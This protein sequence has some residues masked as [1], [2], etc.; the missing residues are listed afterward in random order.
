MEIL[1]KLQSLVGKKSSKNDDALAEK[2]EI[3]KAAKIKSRSHIFVL[4]ALEGVKKLE[5]D[6]GEFICSSPDF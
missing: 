2:L 5:L 1:S 6:G 3:A 4:K